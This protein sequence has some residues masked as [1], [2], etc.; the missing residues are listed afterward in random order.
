[1]IS[2]G[3]MKTTLHDPFNDEDAQVVDE[4]ELFYAT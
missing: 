4:G 2:C 1:M 3:K